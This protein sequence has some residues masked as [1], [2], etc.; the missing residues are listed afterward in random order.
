MVLKVIMSG[1]NVN[2]RNPDDHL[3]S[4]IHIAVIN[5]F[6][7]ISELLIQNGADCNVQDD[8][9]WTPLHYCAAENKVECA[10]LLIKRGA[11]IEQRDIDHKVN[12]PFPFLSFPPLHFRSSNYHN[13]DA[14]GSSDESFASALCYSS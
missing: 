10:V 14:I 8:K 2:W 1:A 9:L 4:A 7:S 13:L 12:L 5:A 11:K 3:H 6:V